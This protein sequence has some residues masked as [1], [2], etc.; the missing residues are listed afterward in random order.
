MIILNAEPQDY[1]R[2]AFSL[3]SQAGTVIEKPVVQSDLPVAI[4]DI[5]AIIVRLGLRIDRKI[6]ESA[7]RLKYILSATT[8]TD[9]IDMEAAK[10]KSIEI[11][12]LKGEESF[13]SSIPST[14]EHTWALLLSLLRHLPQANQHVLNGGWDRQLF[15]GHNLA[16]KKLGIL[17]LGR[18][19][20]QVAR[21]ALAFQCK[22]G[23]Y[24]VREVEAVEGVE[25]FNTPGE[26][27]RWCEIL[28][29]HI[30]YDT[31]THHFL[32]QS[33]LQCLPKGA[34]IVNTSRGGVWDEKA[35]VGLLASGHLAGVAT[36]V[37][38]GEQDPNLRPEN[39]MIQYARNHSNMII[40]PHIAGATFES[41]EMTEIFIANKFIKNIHG[42][43]G[44]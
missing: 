41:M 42:K 32:E 29:I 36:D 24:D 23:A 13:L 44:N 33:L 19:G 25:I 34:M 27:L 14:A 43:N 3:L 17:G 22:I 2:T 7:D 15:R 4:K 5:D 20:K 30:P 31:L 26:M 9:H 11:I 39:P 6:L 8:G 21:Y 40:T 35:V 28:C 12:C 16:G 38:Q 10:K 18:V 37:I 1:S